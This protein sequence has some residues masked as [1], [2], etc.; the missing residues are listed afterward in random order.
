VTA[1]CVIII[2][3]LGRPHLV[4]PLVANIAAATPEDHR[5][6]FVASPRDRVV[7]D[8]VR[9]TDADLLVMGRS[10]T[11]GDY[12]RK[13]NLGY[14]K[15]KE[16][17]MFLGAIDLNFHPGWLTA[18]RGCITEANCV[19]VVGTQDLGNPRVI[20]GQHATHSLVSREYVDSCGTI[21]D[22]W[23][24][25][26]EEYPHEFVDDEFVATAKRRGVW[27]FCRESVVEHM[28]PHWRG[29]DGAPKAETDVLYEAMPRRLQIG[30][31]IFKRRSP[32]WA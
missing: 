26:H 3:M 21:D 4:A 28:H 18:A 11:E 19:H 8:A 15:S 1:E 10:P 23:K 16:P 29:A 17:F 30:R 24:V 7:Q 32:L 20:K 22:N 27:K 2:P 25:L 5:I 31:R 6:L 9:E 12:A 14:A 13:I